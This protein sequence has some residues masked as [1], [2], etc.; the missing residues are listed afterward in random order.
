MREHVPSGA[1]STKVWPDI[2]INIKVGPV[3]KPCNETWMSQ[4]ETE[5]QGLADPMLR[6]QRT[7]LS[8]VEQDRLGVWTTKTILML[9]LT[10]PRDQ[11]VIPASSYH[12]FYHYLRPLPSE[13]IWIGYYNGK[14]DWPIS[15]NV[16]S[17][18]LVPTTGQPPTHPN[19]QAAT[20]AVGHLALVVFWNAF[21]PADVFE[22]GGTMRNIVK[23]I[24]PMSGADINWPPQA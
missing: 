10:H 22:F 3:C 2:P 16:G 4:L 13:Q 14:G 12:W 5:I 23:P 8:A 19:G 1:R 11:R 6:G 21:E 17:L 15:Y 24:W 20:I 18:F 9:Q 7:R